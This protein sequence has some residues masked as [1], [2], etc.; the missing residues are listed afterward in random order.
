[1]VILEMIQEKLAEVRQTHGKGHY[2]TDKAI[3][4]GDFSKKNAASVTSRPSS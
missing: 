2:C 4:K 3:A 1:M